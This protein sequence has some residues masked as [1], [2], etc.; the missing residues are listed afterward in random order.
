MPVRNHD[1]RSAASPAAGEAI[2][3]RSSRTAGISPTDF[4]KNFCALPYRG[5]YDIPLGKLSPIVVNA[6]IGMANPCRN[7]APL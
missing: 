3:L 4:I 5:L 2:A 1:P 6:L 7:D